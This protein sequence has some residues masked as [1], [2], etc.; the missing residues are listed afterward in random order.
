MRRK[1]GLAAV[2][3]PFATKMCMLVQRI[4]AAKP[5]VA[6]VSYY[7]RD[8]LGRR[9]VIILLARLGSRALARR[10]GCA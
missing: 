7:A 3:A 2:C 9:V 5:L 8:N 10:N 1:S 6:A 4:E